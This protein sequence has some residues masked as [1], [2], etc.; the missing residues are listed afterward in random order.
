[1]NMKFIVDQLPVFDSDCPFF[2][3][4]CYTCKLDD[5][6][7]E[8]MTNNIAGKREAEDCRWLKERECEKC[9]K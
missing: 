3:F 2:E 1:M 7:C 6:L 5:C 9:G 8:Y 4:G